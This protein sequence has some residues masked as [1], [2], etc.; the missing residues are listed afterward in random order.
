MMRASP[1]PALVF[2]FLLCSPVTAAAGLSWDDGIRLTAFEEKL[3]FR[4]GGRAHYDYGRIDA[5]EDLQQAFPNLDGSHGA[6]RRLSVSLSGEV[7]DILEIRL[8]VDFAY[9]EEVKDDW[10]RFPGVPVLRNLKFGH[11]KEPFSL[12]MLE[13]GNTVTFMEVPLAVDAFGPS[14]NI[15]AL[16]EW[17]LLEERVTAAAGVFL[18]TGSFSSDGQAKDQIE[19]ANGANVTARVTGLPWYEEKGRKLLHLGLSYSHRFRDEDEAD[20]SSQFRARPESRLTDDRLVSTGRIHTE[21]QDLVALEAAGSYGPLSLQGEYFHTLAESPSAGRLAFTGW[22]LLAAWV[23]T[24]ERRVYD[25]SKGV[26]AGVKPRRSFNF[27]EGS[28]GAVEL[29]C[30][31]SALD[32]N[33]GAVRGGRE[34][35]STVGLNWY[36]RPKVRLMANYIRVVVKDRAVPKI[37]DAKADIVM[38]R[39]QVDF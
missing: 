7:K 10:L 35:N 3:H 14:R 23:V 27:R 6:F 38:A 28:W 30:R 8:E 31:Y 33:D 20:P 32:L 21:R 15:G 19:N 11:M 34:R 29:A 18:N 5:S 36:L 12:G 1:L 26:F 9:R 24:G 22:Y 16:G 39:F 13:S 4:I 17:A 2:V 37:D 25:R